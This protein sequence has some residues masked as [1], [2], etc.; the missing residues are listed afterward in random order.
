MD[1]CGA[2]MFNGWD[3]IR[4]KQKTACFL[5]LYLQS[6]PRDCLSLPLQLLGRPDSFSS[7]F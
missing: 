7:Y 3:L 5:S 2:G 1:I 4:F 6:F